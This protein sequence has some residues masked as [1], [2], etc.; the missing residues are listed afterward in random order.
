M[1]TPGP[2]F[3]PDYDMDKGKDLGVSSWPPDQWK[4]GGSNVWGFVSYD[5]E[6]N[7]IF[8]G[9]G[10]PGV[11]NAEQRPGTT[12]GRAV[13]L[14]VP[15]IPERGSG[16]PVQSGYHMTTMNTT[17]TSLCPPEI[18]IASEVVLSPIGTVT[19]CP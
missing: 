12:N 11:W 18:N 17:K 10:N 15:P 16:L 5:P 14:P 8:H 9:T 1:L 6:S 19:S 3:H 7:L 13:F 2:N 4:L